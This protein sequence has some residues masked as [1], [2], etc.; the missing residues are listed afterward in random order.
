MM[1][2]TIVIG[3]LGLIVSFTSKGQEGQE[4]TSNGF[5]FGLK[6]GVNATDLGGDISN[7]DVRYGLNVGSFVEYSFNRL[8]FASGLFYSQQG[9]E[10]DGSDDDLKLNYLNIPFEL[11][12]YVVP[13]SLYLGTGAQLGFLLSADQEVSE[14][15]INIKDDLKRVD[16][17]IPLAIGYHFNFGLTADLRY[18]LGL[19]DID[20]GFTNQKIKNR[21]TQLTIGYIF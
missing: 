9:A 13:N 15:D 4:V 2:R 12:Y 16:F 1:K 10:I 8:A 7:T 18:N 5:S 11:R 14:R 20:D 6:V 19:N 21:T 17:S 3:I